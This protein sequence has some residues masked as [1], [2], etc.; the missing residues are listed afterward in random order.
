MAC[1]KVEALI[2]FGL[3]AIEKK[4]KAEAAANRQAQGW[5]ISNWWYGTESNA[6]ASN[7]SQDEL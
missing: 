1:E 4:R 6:N 7:V 2:I 3:A 5:G